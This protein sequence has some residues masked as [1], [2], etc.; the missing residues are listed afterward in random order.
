MRKQW[1][2]SREHDKVRTQMHYAKKGII[3]PEMEYVAKVENI[4]SEL[5]RSEC[6]RGRLIIPANINHTHLK[7]M[8]I[9][10][11]VSCKI[12]SNIG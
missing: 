8:A 12:N 3:T 5:V 4:S 1:V 9:G 11:A 2:K 7:P 6:A 10:M